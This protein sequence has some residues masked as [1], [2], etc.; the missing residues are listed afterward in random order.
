MMGILGFNHRMR[1]YGICIGPAAWPEPRPD[2]G[3]KA[4]PRPKGLAARRK[5]RRRM[6]AESRRRNRG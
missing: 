6:A 5:A 2:H 1:P 4:Q 3:H